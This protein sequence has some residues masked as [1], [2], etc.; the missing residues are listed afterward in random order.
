M[1]KISIK[2]PPTFRAYVPIPMPGGP[3]VEVLVTFKHRTKDELHQFTTTREDK[4]DTETF[5]EMVTGWEF[6]DPFTKENVDA[7]LQQRIGT[8]LAAY[9]RYLH[10]LIYGGDGRTGSIRG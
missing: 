7:L 4:T 3:A 10:C 1:A 6:E 5:M 2:P 8:A 9:Q